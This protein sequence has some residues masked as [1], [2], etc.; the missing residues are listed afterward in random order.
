MM[1][2][3]LLSKYPIPYQLKVWFI[4]MISFIMFPMVLAQINFAIP[5][6][7]PELSVI[8]IKE[9]MI[10]Y[11][12][13]FVSNIIFVGV[14]ISADLLSM[15]MGLTAAQA[16]NPMTGDTSPILSEAY[17]IL[18][19]MIFLGI[20]GFQWIFSAI[21]KTFFLMA[22]GY[23]FFINGTVAHNIIVISN[24]IFIIGLGI[25]LPIF[26]VLVLTDVLMGFVAKMMPRMNIFMV[27]LPAKTYIGLTII[28]MLIP[29]IY[30]QLENLFGKYLS[31]II[32]V[33]GG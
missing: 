27:V 20:N 33:L 22:P 17:I 28:L 10:G 1:S 9:F 8:L 4:A 25:A 31:S 18:A 16:L 13:G 11:I 6:N 32:P 23:D 2:A 7:I 15:Q 29:Q 3:P 5:T 19:S 12:V 21:Y 24:Q 30:S 26:S 14:E